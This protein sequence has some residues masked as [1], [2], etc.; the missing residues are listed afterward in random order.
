M[1]MKI[2]SNARKAAAATGTGLLATISI[3]AAASEE[4][5]KQAEIQ[6]HIDAL[7]VLCPDHNVVLFRKDQRF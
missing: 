1:T 6:E 4:N 5:R 3:L 2:K 7:K